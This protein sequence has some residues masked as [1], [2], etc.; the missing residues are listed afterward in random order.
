MSLVCVSNLSGVLSSC[1]AISISKLVFDFD[2][3]KCFKIKYYF[4]LPCSQATLA[5]LGSYAVQAD[6]GDYDPVDHGT[7]V[8]YIRDMPFAPEQTE[9]LLLKIAALHRQH[10]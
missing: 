7:G 8:D 1:N 3:V 2:L 9:E 4:R 10:K 6:V 5:M